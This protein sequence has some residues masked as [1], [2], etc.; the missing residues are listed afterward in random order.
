MRIRQYGRTGC[1]VPGSVWRPFAERYRADVAG[2]PAG[3]PRFRFIS[4]LDGFTGLSRGSL[5]EVWENI[6]PKVALAWTVGVPRG[7]AVYTN[8]ANLLELL[9]IG[10]SRSPSQDGSLVVILQGQ[11]PRQ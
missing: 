8:H 1:K 7:Q 11:E 9:E 10:R 5:D 2:S 4:R 3:E 6:C